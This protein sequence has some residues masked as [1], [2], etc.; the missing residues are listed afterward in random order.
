M[1]S[2]ETFAL[3]QRFIEENNT[4]SFK[5]L[6]DSG[7]D[8][9]LRDDKGCSLLHIAAGNETDDMINILIANNYTGVN[10][11]DVNGETPLIVACKK[12]RI[13]NIRTLIEH[14]ADVNL[15]IE[16][17][18]SYALHFAAKFADK[19]LIEYIFKLMSISINANDNNYQ[20]P[21][22]WACSRKNNVNNVATLLDLG[23]DIADCPY[24]LSVLHFAAKYADSGMIKFLIERGIS[25]NSVNSDEKT[26]LMWACE[27]KNNADNVATLV[28]CGADV[29]LTTTSISGGFSALHYAAEYGDKEIIE[30]LLKQNISINIINS[31]EKTPLI[32]AC[33]AKNNLSN[34]ITLLEHG[35]DV[36]LT[37][38][39]GSSA[40]HYA[41]K[42]AGRQEIE[43]LLIHNIGINVTNKNNETPLYWACTSENNIDNVITL[44]EHGADVNVK[45]S[46]TGESILHIAARSADSEI[47]KCLLD[48]GIS[49]NI[50]DDQNTTP[51]WTACRQT[52]NKDNVTTL[53]TNGADINITPEPNEMDATILHYAAKFSDAETVKCLLDHNV[54]VNAI[55]SD[56]QTPLMW[57]FLNRSNW[58]DLEY[59]RRA[60]DILLAHGA[61]VNATSKSGGYSALHL[62]AQYADG[63]IIRLLINHNIPVNVIDNENKTPLAWAFS[64]TNKLEN[65]AA[66][67]ANGADLNM[68]SKEEGASIL[69][70]AAKS[71]SSEMVKLLLDHNI[72][73][74]V[75]DNEGR[76]PLLWA[77]ESEYNVDNVKM[78][79]E[80]GADIN[81]T[82]KTDNAS[83]LHY[84]SKSSDRKVVKCLLKHNI[85][86][87]VSDNNGWT[88]LMLACNRPFNVKN[89]ARLLAHGADANL[90][91][92]EKHTALH[93]AAVNSDSETVKCLLKHD[94]SVNI[95]NDANLTPLL[96]ACSEI[97][98]GDTVATLLENG[99][100]VNVTL[101]A[102]GGAS[103]LHLA[104]KTGAWSLE[105]IK[106]L[107]NYKVEIDL[108]D[109]NGETPLMA[110]CSVDGNLV[111]VNGLLALGADINKV[112]KKG[113]SALHFAA[114]FASS[115]TVESLLD[116][117]ISVNV[118]DNANKTP[119]MWA[120]SYS[121]NLDKITLLISKG[122]EMSRVSS[123]GRNCLHFAA[124]N[125]DENV[126]KYLIEQGIS[127]NAFTEDKRTPLSMAFE[128][129]K[130]NNV[131]VLIKLGADVSAKLYD[132]CNI[133][134]V[135]A[136]FSD[137]DMIKYLVDYGL[138]V[139]SVDDFLSTPLHSACEENRL[140][141]V[142]CLVS[143]GADVHVKTVE[144]WSLLHVAAVRGNVEMIQYLFDI[145]LDVNLMDGANA[146]P[147]M[148]G[149]RSNQSENVALLNKLSSPEVIGRQDTLASCLQ[150]T[151]EQ[152]R[153][154][155]EIENG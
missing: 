111:I 95:K 60:V 10:V 53:L 84:A 147:L 149:Q 51:L 137:A 104:A 31:D 96:Y 121:D 40:L 45:N 5:Q 93:I 43:C 103:A 66:L 3:A 49:V 71:G 100:D 61:D 25:V 46:E 21:L 87:N 134:H 136:R 112:N 63:E 8:V 98:N 55:D 144:G 109:N 97:T 20:T 56:N 62:A 141:N 113:A 7:I 26:P 6:I 48:R 155:K 145:G 67:L 140:D 86:V 75:L 119:L 22:I 13:N 115:G 89:V 72:S 80:H 124:A 118:T 94:V 107:L 9:S 54:P 1:T 64:T 142:K 154:N 42:C 150:I 152:L 114:K 128:N 146:S 153:G 135:A 17:T 122:A 81:V 85:A 16:S 59:I 30:Y 148:W 50:T 38:Y 35:A 52:K 127:I 105:T 143:L 33:S 83:A 129:N 18:G 123:D 69:H 32:S 39:H 138:S 70:F 79:L 12:N 117:G 68:L 126:L 106:F 139:N 110:A 90:F 125:S 28:E 78:L 15:Q 41:A 82:S 58:D 24:G 88:P 47:I 65:V 99:A 11:A 19:E 101:E 2:Q 102:Q 131:D 76:T 44:L 27:V 92:E 133:L 14:G 37:S 132:G 73:V 130:V 108:E 74:N 151:S 36:N 29:N 34:V 4:E 23:A 91:N 77:C 57:V 116:Q 120:C